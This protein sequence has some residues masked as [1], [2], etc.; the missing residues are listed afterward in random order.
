MGKGFFL[1]RKRDRHLW[2]EGIWQNE[3][4][5]LLW[6]Y[7]NYKCEIRRNA[8]GYLNCFVFLKPDHPLYFRDKEKINFILNL[9]LNNVCAFKKRSNIKEV[10]YWLWCLE[11]YLGKPNYNLDPAN[12]NYKIEPLIYKDMKFAKKEC[13]KIVNALCLTYPGL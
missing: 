6:T 12:H 2:G 8:W 13:K 9:E 3:P 10:D 11:R 5:D 4:D 1:S 7:K